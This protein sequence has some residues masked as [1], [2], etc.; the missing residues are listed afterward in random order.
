MNSAKS[1]T[2]VPARSG[3]RRRQAIVLLLIFLA[4]TAALLL[5]RPLRR[6]VGAT[7][8][9][10][11]Q[12][13]MKMAE[14]FSVLRPGEAPTWNSSPGID[15]FAPHGA[16]VRYFEDRLFPPFIAYLSFDDEGRLEKKELETPTYRQ[17]A[18]YWWYHALS[19]LYSR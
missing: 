8:F 2:G 1:I 14:A 16:S 19:I 12:R 13:G 10:S 18:K 15:A 4:L 3:N 9:A 6:G 17:T 11:L 7:R 5:T